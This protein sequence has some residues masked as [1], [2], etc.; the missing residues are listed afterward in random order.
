MLA[1]KH[2]ARVDPRDA[3]VRYEYEY[4]RHGTQA[5]LAAFDVQTGRVFGQVVPHRS[6]DAFGRVHGRTGRSL[7]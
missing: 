6:A 3:S 1:R 5:L 4:V 2:P 7:P